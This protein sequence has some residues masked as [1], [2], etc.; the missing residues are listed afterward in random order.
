MA[1]LLCTL[2]NGDKIYK[3]DTP[4]TCESPASHLEEKYKGDTHLVM[5][6]GDHF[7][8]ASTDREVT[9]E[10]LFDLACGGQIVRGH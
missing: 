3:G 9:T 2:A 1:K 6:N 7:L 5:E 8:V 10:Y 4:R